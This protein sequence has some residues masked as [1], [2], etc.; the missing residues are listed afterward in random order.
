VS[1][2]G[3][4]LSK[5][6]PQLVVD[7]GE[8]LPGDADT[9]FYRAYLEFILRRVIHDLGNSISGINS[10]SDYHL[11]SGVNDPGL[12]ESLEMIRESA[13]H[14]RNLLVMVG[15]ILQPPETAEEAANPAEI[16]REAAKTVRMLLPRSVEM[17][18]EDGPQDRSA[19]ISLVRG[20]FLR[21]IL[22]LAA[23]DIGHLRVPSGRISLG[24]TRLDTKIQ[25]IYRSNFRPP[26]E[27]HNQAAGFVRNI[28]GEMAAAVTTNGGEFTL[29]M[30][31]PL[32]RI[33]EQVPF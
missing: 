12:Q 2:D 30:D 15:D 7:P 22:G 20:E 10:L 21:K 27:L 11:R 33:E 31:F 25:I 4:P 6:D 1:Q 29:C 19:A 8:V 16:V 24:W 26:S 9:P 18:V 32:V 14:S 3:T 17:H 5:S 28:S 23:M 13:E